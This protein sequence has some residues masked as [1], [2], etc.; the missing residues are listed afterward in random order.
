MDVSK[1]QPH[2]D[3]ASSASHHHIPGP[4]TIDT[5]VRATKL[6]AFDS[7]KP[8]ASKNYRSRPQRRAAAAPR[9]E[10]Q[11]LRSELGHHIK[12]SRKAFHEGYASQIAVT[13]HQ[14][15]VLI[16]GESGN[17]QGNWSHVIHAASLRHKGPFVESIARRFPKNY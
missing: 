3:H 7:S 17:W 4:L 9:G 5:A 16:F 1:P 11:S 13:A 12:S 15:R 10:N 6:G 14:R 2:P 8:L